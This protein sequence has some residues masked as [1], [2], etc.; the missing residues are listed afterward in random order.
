[1]LGQVAN[2]API[3]TRQT[4]VRN[5][6]SLEHVWQSLRA[7]Y[8]FQVSGAYFL[9]FADIRLEHNER[10]QDL[11]QR[12]MAFTED[13]LLQQN[14]P[15]THHGDRPVEDEDMSPSLENMVVLVWLKLIHKD[16]PKLVKQKYATELRSRTLASIK[17]EISVALD[18]LIDELHTT[19]NAR[20]LRFSNSSG[21]RYSSSKARTTAQHPSSSK[22]AP[23]CP[24]CKARNQPHNHYLSKCL[25]LPDSH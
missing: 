2:Y 14:G 13:N 10:P 4:I 25:F 5:S 21:S 17:P 18:S 16:L 15:L 24:I 11:F 20:V 7:H 6:T 1:M 22:S 23:S 3:I 19:T 12:L 9:A 8:G